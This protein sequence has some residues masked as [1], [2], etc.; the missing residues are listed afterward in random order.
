MGTE[1]D[2]EGG[3]ETQ[4]GTETQRGGPKPRGRGIDTW[5]V[6]RLTYVL[7]SPRDRDTEAGRGDLERERERGIYKDNVVEKKVKETQK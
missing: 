4:K 1:K 6:E 7:E 5:R 2:L 3:T